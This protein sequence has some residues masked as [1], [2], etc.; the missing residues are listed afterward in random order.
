M[1]CAIAFGVMASSA[2]AHRAAI[3]VSEVKWNSRINVWEIT[4][5]MSAHDLSPV[6]WAQG[7]DL[8]GSFD[9]PETQLALGLYAIEQF[10][11]RGERDEIDLSYVGSERELD[12]IWIYFEL[13][14]PDQ[15]LFIDSDLLLDSPETGVE[16]PY[17]LVNVWTGE[18]TQSHIFGERDTEKPVRLI[19]DRS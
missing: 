14:T 9:T 18:E 10:S 5:R 13:R 2:T 7:V 12:Q 15:T 11:L 4:H 3:P 8:D 17:A 6:M 16:R 1:A 19:V